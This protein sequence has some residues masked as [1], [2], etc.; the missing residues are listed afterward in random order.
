MRY[1]VTIPEQY[2]DDMSEEDYF[3]FIGDLK[4]ATFYVESHCEEIPEEDE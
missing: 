3:D 4:H 1:R 2:F